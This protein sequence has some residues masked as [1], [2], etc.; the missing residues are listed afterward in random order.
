[1]DLMSTKLKVALA[2]VA[3]VLV[4]KLLIQDSP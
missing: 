4:Y 2:I 3:V 1:V